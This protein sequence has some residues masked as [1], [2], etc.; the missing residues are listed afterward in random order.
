MDGDHPTSEEDVRGLVRGAA[1]G[2]RIEMI[3]GGPAL[4]RGAASVEGA[5]GE[6][7]DATRPVVAVCTCGLTQR[8]PWCDATHKVALAR[9][10][11]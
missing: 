1:G 4:V 9:A 5:D 7:H 2:C 8:G 10:R 11:G 6:V 3:P